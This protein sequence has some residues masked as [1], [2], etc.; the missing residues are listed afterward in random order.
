MVDSSVRVH[1][2]VRW[3]LSGLHNVKARPQESCGLPSDVFV[4]SSPHGHQT[5]PS[6]PALWRNRPD[7]GEVS[8][9]P[10]PPA[11]LF[12]LLEPWSSSSH[13]RIL[14]GILRPRLRQ[15]EQPEITLMQRAHIHRGFWGLPARHCITCFTTH[16]G[17]HLGRGDQLAVEPQLMN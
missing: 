16:W 6:S 12:Q 2:G 15:V 1:T 4:T 14:R 8:T 5:R 3:G 9:D 10:D 17:E 11:C 7:G 13:Q